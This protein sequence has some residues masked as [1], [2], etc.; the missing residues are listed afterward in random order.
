MFIAT[1]LP[2]GIAFEAQRAIDIWQNGEPDNR[3]LDDEALAHLYAATASVQL[4]DLERAAAYLEPIL[5]LPEEQ[6]ISWIRRRMIRVAELLAERPYDHD[7]LAAEIR[8]RIAQC[9]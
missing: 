9:T 4:H 3:L 7:R 5:G 1:T 6:R 8:D 2:A